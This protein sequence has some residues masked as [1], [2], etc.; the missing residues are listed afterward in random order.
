MTVNA[1]RLFCLG[2]KLKRYKIASKE[3]SHQFCPSDL[4]FFHVIIVVTWGFLE[5]FQM[6]KGM[7]VYEATMCPHKWLL[8]CVYLA[9]SVKLTCPR[10]IYEEDLNWG[11]A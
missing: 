2:K 1:V 10:I 8:V 9:L 5:R 11:I 7:P 4:V 3:K 6:C